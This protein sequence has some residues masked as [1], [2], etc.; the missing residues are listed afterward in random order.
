[1]ELSEY[2]TRQRRAPFDALKKREKPQCHIFWLSGFMAEMMR[3]FFIRVGEAND[4]NLWI[5]WYSDDK[6][7]Y[8]HLVYDICNFFK[9]TLFIII[10]S[11]SLIFYCYIIV[12]SRCNKLL[13]LLTVLYQKAFFMQLNVCEIIICFV[14]ILFYYPTTNAL[15]DASEDN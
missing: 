9:S 4:K 1:M 2:L 8:Y 15:L 7:D 3:W 12:L 13:F 14:V 11:N 5:Q 6:V 10:L